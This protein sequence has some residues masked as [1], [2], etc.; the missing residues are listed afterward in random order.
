MSPRGMTILIVCIIGGIIALLALGETA[1]A[2]WNT[3][4]SGVVPVALFATFFIVI[5]ASIAHL[6][7]R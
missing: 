7:R 3:T 2:H 5:M 4:A 1:G 6:L